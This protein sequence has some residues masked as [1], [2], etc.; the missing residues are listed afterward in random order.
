M[1]PPLIKFFTWSACSLTITT[2]LLLLAGFV[3]P[4]S[5]AAEDLAVPEPA[6]LVLLGIGLTAL[7]L[8]VR[9]RRRT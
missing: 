7:A 5:A 2:V 6:M 1:K 4:S 8:R 3:S 9:A